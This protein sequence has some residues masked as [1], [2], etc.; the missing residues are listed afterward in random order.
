M[1][2]EAKSISFPHLLGPACSFFIVFNCYMYIVKTSLIKVNV[3]LK[4]LSS[5][6]HVK[7]QFTCHDV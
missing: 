3:D 7:F 5:E 6:L 4:S 1:Y 2:C